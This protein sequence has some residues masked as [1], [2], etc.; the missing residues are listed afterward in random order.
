[1]FFIDIAVPRD[2]DPA[3]HDIEN[4]FLYD[5]DDLQ[6]VVDENLDERRC[7]RRAPGQAR[8]SQP[9]LGQGR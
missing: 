7:T 1:M 3:V 8:S 9:L 2:I 6:R 5:I 4:V